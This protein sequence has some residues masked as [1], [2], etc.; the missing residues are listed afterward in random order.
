MILEVRGIRRNRTPFYNDFTPGVIKG[1][2]L[3]NPWSIGDATKLLVA[4][5]KFIERSC[6]FTD[7]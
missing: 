3:S 1:V 2:L 6:F 7:I 4:Y 5:S